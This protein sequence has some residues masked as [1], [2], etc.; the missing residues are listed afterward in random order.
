MKQKQIKCL[1]F[2]MT[3]GQEVEFHEIEFFFIFHEVKIPNNDSIS[4][5]W[6]F[7]WDWNSKK[8][9]LGNFDLMI[10]LLVTSMIMRLKFKKHY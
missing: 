8:A 2:E 4:W 9:L 10:D 7:S 6:H 1:M 3:Q 5:S